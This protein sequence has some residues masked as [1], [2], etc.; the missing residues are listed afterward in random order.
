MLPVSTSVEVKEVPGVVLGLI[1]ANVVVFLV[2]IGLPAE[3]AE[4]FISHNALV[5]ARYTRVFLAREMG[6]DQRN[7]L[8]FLTNTSFP[9]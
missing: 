4:Q 5:P 2:Q 6:L 3:L 9:S 7:F 1:V 8:P